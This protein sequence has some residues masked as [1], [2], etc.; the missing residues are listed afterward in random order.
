MDQY[1]D[2]SNKERWT[3]VAT[4][5]VLPILEWLPMFRLSGSALPL[6]GSVAG[7]APPV[8]L[9][10]RCVNKLAAIANCM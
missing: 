7:L 3:A 1:V 9:P 6:S 4:K 10:E 2:D 5:I 8:P